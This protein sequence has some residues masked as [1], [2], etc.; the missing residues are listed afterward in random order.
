MAVINFDHTAA[1]FVFNGDSAWFLQVDKGEAYMLP[2]V[3]PHRGGPLH[4]G[5]LNPSCKAIVCPL[6]DT[7][8]SVG[9]L[10]RNGL[11]LI[12]RRNGC[13]TVVVPDGSEPCRLSKRN[14]RD[15]QSKEKDLRTGSTT[16]Q[17]Q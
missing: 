15:E 10:R 8:I 7:P 1:N 13:G 6:H 14:L 9:W 5:L 11:P 12:M 16:D 3:C 2:A 17:M 4:L